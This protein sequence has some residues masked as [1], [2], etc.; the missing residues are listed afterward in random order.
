MGKS[1]F[2]RRQCKHATAHAKANPRKPKVPISGGT[3]PVKKP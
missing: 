1:N 2:L 3:P